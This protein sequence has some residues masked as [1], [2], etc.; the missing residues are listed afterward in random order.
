MRKLG[1]GILMIAVLAIT[2]SAQDRRPAELPDLVEQYL[3][4]AEERQTDKLGWFSVNGSLNRVFQ[5]NDYNSFL[6]AQNSIVQTGGTY[7]TFTYAPSFGIDFGIML[8]DRFGLGLGGDFWLKIG[9]DVDGPMTTTSELIEAP[10]SNVS[11]IGFRAGVQYYLLNPPTPD[12]FLEG[13]AVKAISS[14]GFYSAS[15]EFVGPSN[16]LNLATEIAEAPAEEFQD[17]KP[18]FELGIGVDYP[19]AKGW[20]VSFS[21]SYLYLN[22]TDV[23]WYNDAD[24][25]IVASFNG[26]E[27]GR[28]DLDFSGFRGRL[29]ITKFF[30]W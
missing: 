30:A 18:A 4:G 1:F 14:I 10:T 21:S 15:W 20:G 8:N 27:S 17:S 22:F 28:V 2:G 13:M 16:T 24:E 29:E 19:F 7:S 5:D 25:E 6:E 12:R 3:S 26:T 9:G 11:V 23:S